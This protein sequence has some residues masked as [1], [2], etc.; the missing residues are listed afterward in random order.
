MQTRFILDNAVR[1]TEFVMKVDDMRPGIS[2]TI[3]DG[4]GDAVSLAACTPTLKWWP[5]GDS[6]SPN[7]VTMTVDSEPAGTLSYDWVSG[8]L[9]TVGKFLAEIELDFGPAGVRTAPSE[10]YLTIRVLESD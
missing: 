9:D 6:S 7:S 4:N 3:V 5:V 8:D 10:G 2:G 1:E